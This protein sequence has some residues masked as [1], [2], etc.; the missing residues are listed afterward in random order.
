MVRD[1]EINGERLTFHVHNFDISQP[2]W[3]LDGT[4]DTLLFFETLE[5]LTQDP[6]GV[7]LNV[8]KRMTPVSTLV[9][10]VPNAV[11]YKTLQ[12]LM[13]GAPPWT[14]WFFQPDLTHEPRHSFEYTPI[15]FKILMRSAG[16]DELAFRTMTTFV[17]PDSIKDYVEIGRALSV[18]PRMFGETMIAQARK[19]P[20][21]PLFRYPDCIYDSERYYK[22]THP[23]LRPGLDAAL[24]AFLKRSNP[25]DAHSQEMNERASAAIEAEQKANERASAA[26]EAEKEALFLCDIDRTK[27]DTAELDLRAAEERAQQAEERALDAM[28]QH[29]LIVR[30]ASWRATGPLRSALDRLRSVAQR[31]KPS[32]VISTELVD[33]DVAETNQSQ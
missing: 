26:V 30:S 8:T 7:M 23:L 33:A 31:H 18:E 21:E 25:N 11:S 3:P 9:I 1:V 22:S 15:F 24:D 10:S 13:T 19:A 12:E 14:H 20:E 4:F 32:A 29:D 16:L 2:E 6:S 27:L 28:F 5:H 17:E